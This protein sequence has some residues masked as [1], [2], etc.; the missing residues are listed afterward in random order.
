MW[1]GLAT[2]RQ[3]LQN[4]RK[5]P[6]VADESMVIGGGNLAE[7]PIFA[8]HGHEHQMDRRSSSRVRWI[9]GFS[10]LYSVVLVPFS[11]LSCFSQPDHVHGADGVWASGEFAQITEMNHLMVSDSMRYAILM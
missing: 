4:I 9:K 7:L 3:N 8:G 5:S 10:V 6:R 11:A 2:M 1:R